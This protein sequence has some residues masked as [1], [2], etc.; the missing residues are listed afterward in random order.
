MCTLG[1][2]ILFVDDVPATIDFYAA[3]F[4]LE[5]GFLHPEKNYGEMQ[6]GTVTKLAFAANGFVQAA[7]AACPPSFPPSLIL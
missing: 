2:V 5:K 7:R 3:A 4:G 6:T 1:Y